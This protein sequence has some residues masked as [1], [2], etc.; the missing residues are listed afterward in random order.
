MLK[1]GVK[2][3]SFDEYDFP[4]EDF[5]FGEV[6]F[7]EKAL[8]MTKDDPCTRDGDLLFNH[9]RYMFLV[10]E[11]LIM[12]SAWMFEHHCFPK[13]TKLASLYTTPLGA[14]WIITA[15]DLSQTIVCHYSEA[16]DEP[17]EF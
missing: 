16:E 11:R 4:G 13:E 8:E 3:V 17:W 2:L 14:F 10:F 12:G 5:M 9:G 15:R 6:F 1:P 7:S